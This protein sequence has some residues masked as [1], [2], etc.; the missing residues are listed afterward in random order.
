M[1]EVLPQP[2]KEVTVR[3]LVTTKIPARHGCVVRI[4]VDEGLTRERVFLPKKMDA[5]VEYDQ[6]LL[7]VPELRETAVV[8]WNPG[9]SPVVLTGGEVLGTLEP[10]EEQEIITYTLIIRK[11]TPPGPPL[12]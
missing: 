2:M 9:H 6:V 1:G 7:T 12:R 11:M 3:L 5:T 4:S 10:L 8:A